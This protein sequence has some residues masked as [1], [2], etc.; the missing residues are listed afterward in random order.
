[1]ALESYETIDLTFMEELAGDLV[2]DK[3]VEYWDIEGSKKIMR[4]L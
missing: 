3:Q 2:P 4:V 1:M